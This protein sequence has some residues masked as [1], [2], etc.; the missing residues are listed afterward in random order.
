ML[1]AKYV[2][3]SMMLFA[4]PKMRATLICTMTRIAMPQMIAASVP[5][6]LEY[7]DENGA[8]GLG[9]STGTTS[10]GASTGVGTSVG[11]TSAGAGASATGAGAGSSGIGSTGTSGAGVGTKAPYPVRRRPY[12]SKASPQANGPHADRTL[13]PHRTFAR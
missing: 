5:V 13:H 11:A 1:V 3:A 12:L 10:T 2:S 7:S 9:T 8:C 6:W 4:L